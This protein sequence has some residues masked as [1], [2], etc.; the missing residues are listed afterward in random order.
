MTSVSSSLTLSPTIILHP[1]LSLSSNHP[2]FLAAL[3]HTKVCHLAGTPPHLSTHP[4]LAKTPALSLIPSILAHREPVRT[5]L[6]IGYK[7]M[8]VW[9]HGQSWSFSVAL[10]T[11]CC[12]VYLCTMHTF[13]HAC[14]LLY[15]SPTGMLTP[16]ESFLFLLFMP[17]S[18]GP[19]ITPGA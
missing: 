18:S 3:E 14:W 12:A 19:K 10:P 1:T 7:Y 16:R 11:F 4:P 9:S 15:A 17:V 5:F 2:L 13:S 8:P 6:S